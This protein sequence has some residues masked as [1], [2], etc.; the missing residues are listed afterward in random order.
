MSELT[1]RRCR[2]RRTNVPQLVPQSLRNLAAAGVATRLGW[3]ASFTLPTMHCQGCQLEHDDIETLP[4]ESDDRL[5]GAS[6]KGLEVNGTY[7][8]G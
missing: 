8:S 5:N 1:S 6:A 7:T 3:D 4:V 2:E